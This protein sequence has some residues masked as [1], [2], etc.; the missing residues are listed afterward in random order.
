MVT[1]KDNMSLCFGYILKEEEREYSGR[2]TIDCGKK[3]SQR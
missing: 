1:N 3:K 2:F